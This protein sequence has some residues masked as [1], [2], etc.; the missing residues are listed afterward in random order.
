MTIADTKATTS[1]DAL[2]DLI[3]GELEARLPHRKPIE[4]FLTAIRS[5]PPGLRAMAATYE[6]DVSITLDD[7]G[8]HFGNWHHVGLAA[9]TIQGLRELGAD[10]MAQLVTDAFH[11]AQ[12][13]WSE[14]GSPNWSRWY[15][16]SP[17]E[18]S[19]KSLNREAWE[20]WDKLPQG[21]Y[22]YWL[23]YARRYPERM[24]NGLQPA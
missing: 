5:L 17:L 8:W 12:R 6:L 2:Y 24:V 14:L 20:I 11:A 1:D 16:G 19:V 21:L 3:A 9:E 7:L 23:S 4:A 18:E 22:S 10:R 13:F 15:H